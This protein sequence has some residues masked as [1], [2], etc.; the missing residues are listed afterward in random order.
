M[1]QS[2]QGEEP[3]ARPAREGIV[4]PSGGEPLLL[5]M[6][7]P[8]ADPVAP[9]SAP[10]DGPEGQT[11]NTSWGSGQ[12]SP[13]REEW[14]PSPP[15]QRWGPQ[16]PAS[17]GPQEPEVGGQ[18]GPGPLSPGGTRAPAH[19]SHPSYAPE[20]DG[21]A[22]GWADGDAQRG[23]H[24]PFPQQGFGYGA[25]AGSYDSGGVGALPGG[26]EEATQF[27]PPVSDLP[28]D[29]GA[30]QFIPPVDPGALSPGMPAAHD[31]E[32][33][34]YLGP[35]AQSRRGG[36][37]PPV[38]R[39][40]DEATQFMAPVTDLPPGASYGAVPGASP[41]VPADEGNR[42]PPAEFDSLFR[43]SRG[44][45]PAES[46]QRMPRVEHQRPSV[47]PQAGHGGGRGGRAGSKTPLIAAVGVGL[48]VL[49]V[50]AGALL[51]DGGEDV[52]SGQVVATTAPG[53]GAPS[54]ESA[55][56]SSDGPTVDPARQ[57]AVELDKL[58]AHSGDSRS[59]VINAVEDVKAC[60]N[61][62]QAAGD[63]REAAG[64]R[65]QLVADL[66]ALSVDRLPRHAALTAALTKAWQASASA[67]NHYAAWADQAAGKKGCKKGQARST[68][69]TEAANK[70]SGVA[71]VE[72][73]KA[74]ELWNGIAGQHGLTVRQSTQL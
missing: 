27:I 22:P 65:D 4:L 59:A 1:T 12:P 50:G 61:L 38:G 19:G 66:T 7:V 37:P 23:G 53:N 57:Q 68:D 46:T 51:G 11:W 25:P 47:P 71:T 45:V 56:E 18:R 62:Q 41:A 6:K 58:L 40:D 52:D 44:E 31:F 49:G 9:A 54:D 67:D 15:V 33:V 39:P 5:G 55:V 35:P 60:E 43:A 42:Q 30:T 34:R 8:S 13:G 26:S 20:A 10:P 70:A 73:T 32:A 21:S 48:A 64:Q 14:Q 2:G 29:E 17:W 28:G 69:E 72:K 74:A 36:P 63:L 3:S 16:E 24:A